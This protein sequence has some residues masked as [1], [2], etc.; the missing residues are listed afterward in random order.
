M[1]TVLAECIVSKL[2]ASSAVEEADRELYVYGFFLLITRFFFFLVA[3]VFGF[4][5]G[6]LCESVIFFIVFIL[7]RSYAGGVHA[8]TER[9]CILWTT[10]A[11]GIAVATIK[12][13]TVSNEKAFPLLASSNLC[14]GIFSPMDSMEKPLDTGEKMKYRAIT[15]GLLLICDVVILV[16]AIRWCPE[17]YYSI[18]CGLFLEATLLS[19]GKVR[20]LYW[21]SDETLL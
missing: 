2:I 14:I 4:I 21:L 12:A 5:L 9:A 8:K 11:L 19:I 17:L 6:I 7:L 15:H 3:V 10:L 20:Q 16:A 13:L 18:T 1:T